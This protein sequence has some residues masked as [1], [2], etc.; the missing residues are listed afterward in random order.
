MLNVYWINALLKNNSEEKK[1]GI[2]SVVH[3]KG[4]LKYQIEW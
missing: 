2:K 1:E 4:G 3:T